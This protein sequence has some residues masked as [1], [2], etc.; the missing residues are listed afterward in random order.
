MAKTVTEDYA[1]LY[2]YTTAE[3]LHG[4]ITSQHLRA[5]NIAFLNDSEER[6]RYFVRRMPLLIERAVQQAIN[7]LKKILH[8]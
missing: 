2:H 7:E 4:I 5:T 3:G 8:L 1:E 6:L